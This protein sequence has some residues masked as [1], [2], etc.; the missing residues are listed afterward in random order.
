MTEVTASVEIDAPPTAV[1]NRLVDFETYGQ[2][3]PLLTQIEGRAA[4]GERVRAVVDQPGFPPLPLRAEVTAVEPG[5]RLSWVSGVPVRQVLSAAHAF[6]L[7][8]VGES[9]TRFTQCESF[10]GPAGAFVP[11]WIADRLTDGFDRMNRALKYRVEA[12]TV[13]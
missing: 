3:N 5:R 12:D 13:R 6:E 8:P 11:R 4:V 2:W 9:R 7:A 10:G 1:W